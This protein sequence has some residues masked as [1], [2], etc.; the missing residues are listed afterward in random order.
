MQGYDREVVLLPPLD[1]A[2]SPRPAFV[3]T[4]EYELEEPLASD[5]GDREDE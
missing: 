1:G 5:E 3:P 4:G 2:A